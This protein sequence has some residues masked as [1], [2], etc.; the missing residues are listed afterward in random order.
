MN[1][2]TMFSLIVVM[3]WATHGS[4]YAFQ[5]NSNNHPTV[6]LHSAV[7]NLSQALHKHQELVRNL[8]DP[9]HNQALSWY[10]EQ[11]TKVCEQAHR[12]YI[13]TVDQ[14]D[15]YTQKHTTEEQITLSLFILEQTI[16]VVLNHL[17][18]FKQNINAEENRVFEVQHAV[19]V[20]QQTL[21]Q[22]CIMLSSELTIYKK[23]L[24]KIGLYDT[25]SII[26]ALEKVL[27]QHKIL[28]HAS[29]LKNLVSIAQK[30][31]AK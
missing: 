29:L 24:Q 10:I 30:S 14:I 18:S 27:E 21:V 22:K 28:E 15:K 20:Y 9:N 17:S 19:R 31:S 5:N 8:W 23:I 4:N 26:D 13:N 1:I 6:A 25:I 12:N 16:P 7:N 11:Q 3:L 2:R